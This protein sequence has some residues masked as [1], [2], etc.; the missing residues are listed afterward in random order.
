MSLFRRVTRYRI[1][2]AQDPRENRLTEV[3]ASVLERVDGLALAVLDAVLA[4]AATPTHE[5]GFAGPNQAEG[6]S[7]EAGRGRLAIQLERL[8]ALD[9][10]RLRVHTQVTTSSNKFVDLE[11]RVLPRPFEPG[12]KF[13]FWL[14]VKHGAGVHGSQL[15]DYETDIQLADADQRL[16]LVL[17]PRQGMADLKGVPATMPVV[18][19]PTVADVVRCW[20]KRAELGEVERFLLA[21]Y[22]AY[23]REEG[24]MDEELLTA[25]HAFALRA[26]PASEGAATKLIEL[27]DGYIDDQWGPRGQKKGGTKPAYGLNYWAH[28][29]L[30]ARGGDDA[31]QTWRSTTFEWSLITDTSREEPRNAWVFVA[32][33]TFYAARDSPASLSENAEWLA[34]RRQDG[35][36]YVSAWYWRLFRFRYPEELLVAT[37]LDEQVS[38]LGSWVVD[39]FRRLAAAPPPR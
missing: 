7:R 1:G 27:A 37:T 10:P 18:A 8:R 34:A 25:E 12:D 21:D 29:G 38:L 24:L 35:F 17:T 11:L 32:G 5:T 22:L 26:Q 6:A 30:S 13:L 14:E 9:R 36:E 33:A 15:T 20:A 4:A 16:V 39:S 2:P 31:P 23:L 19:W 3:T 28:Y